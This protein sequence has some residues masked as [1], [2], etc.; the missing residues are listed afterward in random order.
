[1]RQNK[2]VSL[3][4]PPLV[5]K[6][7]SKQKFTDSEAIANFICVEF[8]EG[9]EEERILIPETIRHNIINAFGTKN[10]NSTENS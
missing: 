10:G 9:E 3:Y 4:F 8:S 5:E 1:M 7:L 2:N 6:F